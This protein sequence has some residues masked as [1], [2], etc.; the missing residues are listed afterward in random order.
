MIA[1]RKGSLAVQPE[2]SQEREASSSVGQ[3]QG[4]RDK[5]VC[6]RKSLENWNTILNDLAWITSD[7]QHHRRSWFFS[8]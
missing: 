8:N 2:K 4:W 3:K 1:P 5:T 6:F 7:F